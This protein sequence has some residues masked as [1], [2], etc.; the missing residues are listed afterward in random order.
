MCDE[1]VECFLVEATNPGDAVEAVDG[2]LRGFRG[3]SRLLLPTLSLLNIRRQVI[4]LLQ[5]FGNFIEERLENFTYGSCALSV[6]VLPL[7]LQHA[8][9]SIPLNH[10]LEYVP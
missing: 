2:Y 7:P 5:V 8:S 1:S 9:W 6:V 10:H 3:R 4:S